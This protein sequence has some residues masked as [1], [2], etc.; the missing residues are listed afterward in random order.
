MTVFF[1][2]NDPSHLVWGLDPSSP[3]VVDTHV[4]S[5]PYPWSAH[6]LDQSHY[7]QISDGQYL[8]F[9]LGDGGNVA[10]VQDMTSST[11]LIGGTGRDDLFGGTN[12]A[13]YG[14][15]G[16]D[17]LFTYGTDNKSYGGAGDDSMYHLH[18]S[19]MHAHGGS[20][21][22]YI[23][24]DQATSA[25]IFGGSGSD[26]IEFGHYLTHATIYGGSGDAYTVAT[27]TV[28]C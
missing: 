5:G 19:H 18:R 3:D 27:Q 9:R 10:Q 12:V 15:R 22:D 24:G 6:D 2:S 28:K 23:F 4:V 20:G 7:T 11:S 17:K 26:L 21:D 14:G 1:G 8:E 25:K 13:L 16:N